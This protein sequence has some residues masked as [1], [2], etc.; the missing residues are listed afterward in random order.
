MASLLHRSQ[1]PIA[2]FQPR[3]LQ[4]SWPHPEVQPEPL[5]AVLQGVRQ[6]HRLQE[7]R[8]GK[9][10]CMRRLGVNKKNKNL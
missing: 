2:F 8:L 3:L 5:P 10:V 1:Y 7:A 9:T 4:P 6:G